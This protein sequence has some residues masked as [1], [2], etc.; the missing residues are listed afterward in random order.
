MGNT[1][2]NIY[3]RVREEQQHKKN[4]QESA[5]HDKELE[6]IYRSMQVSIQKDIDAFYTRYATKEGIS[7]AEAKKRADKLDIEAYAE[8]AKKYVATHDLSKKA[9]SE[10]RLYNMTM[11]VNRL[12]LLK[13]NI[14]MEL[15]EKF[16]DMN[17]YM[18]DK[19][20]ERTKDELKRQAGILGGS[21]YKSE[22]MAASIV[23]ASFHSATY[24]DRIWAHQDQ[25]KYELH[26]LLSIGL[27]QGVNPKKLASD[28]AKT[29]GVSLRNA[30]RLMRTE[31][32][33]VQT[34]AQFESYKRN[35][36]EYY[37]Y[38]TLGAQACPICRPLDGKIFKVSEMLISENAP[39]MH[40]N[41]RCS[42]SASMGPEG[43]VNYAKSFA[44]SIKQDIHES[45]WIYSLEDARKELLKS[46][47]GI[48]TINAIKNSDVIINVINM[49]M[50]PTGARG[51]Q[52]GNR[53]DIYARQCQNKLV[54]SQ[55]IVHEM[56]HY[57]FG[58]GEC[59]HAEAICFAMEK[60]HKERRDYLKPNE[61]EYVKKLA[62]DTYPE[63]KWE[64]G[65]YGNYEQFD[66]V[67]DNKSI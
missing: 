1:P 42:T 17:D 46:P 33:R 29:F 9:N 59:Q 25:L 67:R 51:E 48:D 65:G 20:T 18:N 43:D 39:P 45:M 10:M 22:E 64:E 8:K 44:D 12:E 54:F 23:G 21:A 14:G 31:M 53:I 34:D 28:V 15:V 66:F 36:F 3:W 11:K 38:H 30:Q 57:R 63:L 40:P 13:A 24:S 47:V 62:Q 26:K 6:K 58:I 60:M 55:T 52:G 4:L 7:M 49:R 35:G 19:L 2:S 16:E 37:Q 27:I 50:H 32:A 41:C 61:W 56:A 5:N